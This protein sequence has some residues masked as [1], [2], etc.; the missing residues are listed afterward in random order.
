MLAE[1]ILL[2]AIIGKQPKKSQSNR[3]LECNVLNPVFGYSKSRISV[4]LNHKIGIDN[5]GYWSVS[6]K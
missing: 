5:T 4:T 2:D 1:G 6:L 3:F